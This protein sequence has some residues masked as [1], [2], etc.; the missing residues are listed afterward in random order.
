MRKSV[1]I[2]LLA[3][4]VC[5]ASCAPEQQDLPEDAFVRVSGPY[6]I[7]PSGDT[8][9]IKGTNLG[10]W[11]NPEGYMF[12][13]QKTNS[14]WMIDQMFK[15]MVGP[16]F[17]AEFWKMF[18]DNY[19]TEKDIEFIAS[20]Q[21]NYQV[22]TL[23]I[24][25]ILNIHTGTVS[26]NAQY[27]VLF[28]KV[29]DAVFVLVNDGNGMSLAGKVLQDGLADSSKTYNDNFHN[30]LTQHKNY[31]CSTIRNNRFILYPINIASP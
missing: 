10:N 14:A 4:L 6:L 31:D 26:Y 24:C 16:D 22:G 2:T 5:M 21:R 3:A 20:G 25:L 11:L 30:Q 12:G 17:T 7:E 9:F 23:Y 18:K 27:I 8:L 19:V 28:N 29:F 1:F 15:E 13:F